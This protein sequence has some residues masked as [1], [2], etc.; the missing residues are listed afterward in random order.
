MS[1]R[2]PLLRAFL[3]DDEPLALKRLSRLIAET[4]RVEV[5][6]SSADPLDAVERIGN[7]EVDV[8]FLDIHM[9]V[10]SGFE[11]PDRPDRQPL[12]NFTNFFAKDKLP[13]AATPE[14]NYV[15]DSTIAEL[16][17]K[18]DPKKFVHVH[19]ST[20]LNVH[21]VHE[22]YSWFAGRML[23]RLKDGKHTELTVARDRVRVLKER[24]GI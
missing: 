7:F 16:E 18:L 12:V 11:L 9:P 21:H 15:V 20:L 10:L 6:G 19:R 5:I 24:L 1:A 13:F 17:Q 8:L 4:G 23:V 3:V 2:S 22:L 14:K